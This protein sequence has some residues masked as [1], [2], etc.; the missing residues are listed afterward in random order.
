MLVE[1]SV[2]LYY[3]GVHKHMQFNQIIFFNKCKILHVGSGGGRMSITIW[4]YYCYKF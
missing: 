4:D 1:V 2:N 3:F